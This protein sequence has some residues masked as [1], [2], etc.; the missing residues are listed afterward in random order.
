MVQGTMSSVGKS[1]IVTAL[2]RIFAQDG[3]RVAPFKA[4]NMALNSFV[5]ADGGEV[6]RAQA[7]QA[8]AAGVDVT[9]EMNPVLIKPEGPG[10]AQTVVLG[11]PWRSLAAEDYAEHRRHLWGVVTGALDAL[12]ERFE[13]VVIEGAGSPVE[14]NLKGA[15]IVNMA[16][17][18]HADAPVALVGDID[19]GGVFAQLLGT[20]A[21]LDEG[22]RRRVRGLIVNKFR[23]DLR[24]FAGGVEILEARAGVPVLGVVPFVPQLR[25]AEEDAVALDDGA[26]SLAPDAAQPAAA[27]LDIAI[28]RLPHVSNFDDFDP[29]LAEP[30]VRVRYVAGAQELGRPDLLVLPGTKATLA[31]LVFLKRVGLFARIRELAQRDETAVL[32]IC[33]GYQMLG[34]R[35]RDPLVVEGWVAEAEGLGLLPIETVFEPH[36]QTVRTRGR[37]LEVPGLFAAAAGVELSGYEIHMGRTTPTAEA[38]PLVRILSRGE[39]PAEGHDGACS[40]SGWVAGTYLHGLF[41]NDALRD[42]LLRGLRARRPAAAQ[43]APTRFSRE[44]GYER[45]AASVRQSLDL[46]RLYGIIQA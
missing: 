3:L 6:G 39:R 10:R 11:R 45:L 14:L 13:L 41:D 18:E 24:R 27:S 29:L 25:L 12:R 43:T 28:V 34:A 33:G 15:D 9:V 8:E 26:P 16:V 2:C 35:V 17:A 20:L 42:A 7:V 23:G 4:Q 31:D 38:P 5:T 44:P 30:G 22:E 1:T 19:R 46:A 32:G 40:R 21:L 37:V 36:K